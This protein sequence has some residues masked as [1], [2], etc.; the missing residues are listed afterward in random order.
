MALGPA[1]S[2]LANK[3]MLTPGVYLLT[4][5]AGQLLLLLLLLSLCGT[6]SFDVLRVKIGSGAWTVGRWK[7]PEKRNRVNI[8]D[9]QFRTYGEKKP[10][11]GS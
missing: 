1:R 2:A 9:V 3:S 5:G 10:L 8:F 4:A 7:N 11:E 6:T